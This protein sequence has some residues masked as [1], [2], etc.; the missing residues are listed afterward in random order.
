MAL[1]LQHLLV[2]L[3]VIGCVAFVARQGVR[4][5]MGRK[6]KLGSCCAKGCEMTTSEPKK[7]RV[8]FLPS[9][10]LTSSA[11]RSRDH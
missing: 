10:M 4:S 11:R 7:D 2:L 8:V 6:N 5:L 1:W 9:D 3:I